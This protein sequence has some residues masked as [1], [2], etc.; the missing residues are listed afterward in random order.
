[1][2]NV[3]FACAGFLQVWQYWFRVWHAWSLHPHLTRPPPSNTQPLR[4]ILL[5]LL[6]FLLASFLNVPMRPSQP[7]RN[8][9]TSN[10][11]PPSSPQEPPMIHPPTK[12]HMHVPS[13]SPLL[14][15]PEKYWNISAETRHG[16]LPTT[17]LPQI[18]QPLTNLQLDPMTRL[19][20]LSRGRR[21]NSWPRWHEQGPQSTSCQCDIPDQNPHYRRQPRKTINITNA[22]WDNGITSDRNDCNTLYNK[23]GVTS[24]S[25]T[26]ASEHN[27]RDAVYHY[28]S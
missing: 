17:R 15:T 13:R 24:L 5:P 16:K 26:T 11:P 21:A 6:P 22:T 20:E 8:P 25:P 28:P 7:L 3:V 2:I 1:M 4:H 23:D 10:P 19:P 12:R 14:T 9:G 18:T 27:W